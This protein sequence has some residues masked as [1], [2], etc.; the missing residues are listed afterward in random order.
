MKNAAKP[1]MPR[2]RLNRAQMYLS[3]FLVFPKTRVMRITRK[4][5]TAN[6]NPA[7]EKRF[8]FIGVLLLTCRYRKLQYELCTDFKHGNEVD[9]ASMG[10]GDDVADDIQAEARAFT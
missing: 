10:F 8:R 2:H 3:F 5:V 1:Q 9:F 7:I 6:N 4:Q